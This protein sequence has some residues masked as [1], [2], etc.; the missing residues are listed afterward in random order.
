MCTSSA[1]RVGL[2]PGHA[3]RT[4]VPRPT[5]APNRST[6]AAA[7][8]R[9]TGD[10]VTHRPRWRSNPSPSTVGADTAWPARAARVATRA[11]RSSSAAGR[12]DPV[13]EGIDGG[14]GGEAFPHQE[15]P[16]GADGS[17]AFEARPLLRASEEGRHRYGAAHS[18]Q[19]E[20]KEPVFPPGYGEVTSTLR[21][22]TIRG[23]R[24]TPRPPPTH[25]VPR[26]PAHV[27]PERTPAHVAPRSEA[28]VLAG[29][30]A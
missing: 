16:G 12:P 17:E 22:L 20:G 29:S 28:E 6:R 27:D 7:S 30:E 9:S 11:R 2:P 1:L 19:R 25:E 3:R 21:S 10:S 14:R 18:P 24:T 8:A 23:A 15:E 13:L 26:S 4:S 5:T